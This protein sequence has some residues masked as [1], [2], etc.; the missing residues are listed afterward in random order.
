MK[1]IVRLKQGLKEAATSCK[2]GDEHI[3][4]TKSQGKMLAT[5]LKMPELGAE[6]ERAVMQVGKSIE[7]D[8]EGKST[9]DKKD[10]S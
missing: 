4:I 1:D 9:E 8:R 7:G 2:E 3:L 6:V 10:R 5:C